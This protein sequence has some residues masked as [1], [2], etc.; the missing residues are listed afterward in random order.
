MK[1]NVKV[2]N[3][4]YVWYAYI[5]MPPLYKPVCADRIILQIIAHL[6]SSQLQHTEWRVLYSRS[7]T[8]FLVF[9][10]LF[11]NVF[12]V[13]IKTHP[14]V[15]HPC[16]SPTKTQ[17]ELLL[18]PGFIRSLR[19]VVSES[20]LPTV[21]FCSLVLDTVKSRFL[22][23]CTRPSILNTWTH[24]MVRSCRITPMVV[25]YMLSLCCLYDVYDSILN[26]WIHL[27]VHS[28]WNTPTVVAQY[29][30]YVVCPSKPNRVRNSCN[31]FVIPRARRKH[32]Q[33]RFFL[34]SWRLWNLLP[35]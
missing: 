2:R 7:Y 16:T 35:F 12:P 11:S 26:T 24:R 27:M 4:D 17:C 21:S 3:I 22:A 20:V 28:C 9:I 1:H 29:C 19:Y 15:A 33:H 10:S 30:L 32:F 14:D 5:D 6:D 34:K 23:C 31:R 8:N 18:A 25:V 13:L